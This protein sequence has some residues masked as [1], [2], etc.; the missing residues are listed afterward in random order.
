MTTLS[1]P[2]ILPKLLGE[3]GD[4]MA[5]NLLDCARCASEGRRLEAVLDCRGGIEL[6]GVLKCVQDGH[7]W[8]IEIK[9]EKVVAVSARLPH[10]YSEGLKVS[11][12]SDLHED[13]AE[14]ER[15]HFNQCYKS[16]ATMIRRVLQLALID[17]TISDAPLSQMLSE[18]V[19]RGLLSKETHA[20]ASVLKTFGD[21]GAHRR[22]RLDPD[23]VGF[24]AM[25]AVR[26]LNELFP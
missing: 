7:E 19:R 25:M 26:L 9:R 24:A 11:V 4:E 3:G 17:K 2:P 16:S 13:M 22:Q 5:Q 21:I 1:K 18:A 10:A 12:P 14:A 15:A 20:Q 23:D 6:R 8:P